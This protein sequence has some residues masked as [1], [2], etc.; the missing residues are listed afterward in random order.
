LK[1]AFDEHVPIV[2]VRVFKAFAGEKTFT[3][4]AGNH[5]VSC[6]RDYN[7]KPG[8]KGFGS[9]SDVP[10]IEKFA[11]TG[12]KVIVS[13]N[14][15]MKQVP[16]ERLALT[17]AGMIVIFFESRWSNWNFF[18][19][20]ALLLHWWP[21]VAKKL[22]TAKPKEFWCI[23]CAWDERGKLRELSNDDEKKL[24][25]ERQIGARERVRQ[26][27]AEKR[28]LKSVTAIAAKS[29]A[30]LVDL[31]NHKARDDEASQSDQRKPEERQGGA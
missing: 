6:S 13:G 8:E 26:E 10:W 15:R 24:K 9:K 3:R 22:R 16:H 25:I 5:E 14:T 30:D 12:G 7:P 27:R 31:M 28:A 20:S 21:V 23:P 11:A 19:K 4:I 18:R 1:I 17:N 29:D 2:L